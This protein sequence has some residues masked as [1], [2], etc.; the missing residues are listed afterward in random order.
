MPDY[1]H[2]SNDRLR[3]ETERKASG[4]GTVDDWG[5]GGNPDG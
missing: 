2:E 3:M 5:M 4:E 1:P